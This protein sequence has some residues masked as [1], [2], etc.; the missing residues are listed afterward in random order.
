MIHAVGPVWHGGGKGEPELLAGC[1]RRAFQLAREHRL[2]TIA[3]PAISAGVYGYPMDKACRIALEETKR[4]L[5]ENPGLEKV[6]LVA[7][8]PEALSAYRK[9]F[10][11]LFA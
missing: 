6:L 10:E 1:Y 4:A 9:A 11:E 5:A 3:F 7:Y 2:A 8:S